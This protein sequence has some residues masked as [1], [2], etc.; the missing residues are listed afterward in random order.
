VILVM[1]PVRILLGGR[2]SLRVVM[3]FLLVERANLCLGTE[4]RGSS[5]E[6]SCRLRCNACRS[7]GYTCC[8]EYLA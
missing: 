3:L 5:S 6:C 8:S 4:L 7:N 1:I 2:M